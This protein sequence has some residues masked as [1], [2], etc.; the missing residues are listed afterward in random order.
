MDVDI[1][2]ENEKFSTYKEWTH[3]AN[4]IYVHKSLGGHVSINNCHI[5]TRV[6]EGD[7]IF[8]KWFNDMVGYQ[9]IDECNAMLPFEPMPW[10]DYWTKEMANKCAK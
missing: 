2:I 10:K 3:L 5:N 7:I 6:F 1:T 9:M 4:R 8:A